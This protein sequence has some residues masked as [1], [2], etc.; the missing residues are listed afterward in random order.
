VNT[1]YVAGI[2]AGTAVALGLIAAVLYGIRCVVCYVIASDYEVSF[3]FG[4]R[5][6]AVP[7]GPKK[8]ARPA[9]ESVRDE[10]AA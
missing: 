1:V 9:L 8:A 2:L 5:K 4:K 3:R 6:V 10:G 7:R